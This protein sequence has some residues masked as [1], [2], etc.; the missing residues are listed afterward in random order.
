MLRVPTRWALAELARFLRTPRKTC[1]APEKSLP[2][3]VARD[4]RA[5]AVWKREARG[6]QTP[7]STASAPSDDAFPALGS[8]TQIRV[9]F[10]H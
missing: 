1:P 9:T 4:P 6:M 5:R 8:E 10:I 7:I 3:R 2:G